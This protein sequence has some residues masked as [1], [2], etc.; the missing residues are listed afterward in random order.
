MT[1]D[2]DRKPAHIAHG[3]V[4]GVKHIV[5]CWLCGG[6][7]G[8]ECLECMAASHRD[9]RA[10]YC[11]RCSEAAFFLRFYRLSQKVRNDE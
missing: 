2:K 11:K 9:G 4:T 10:V 3:E 8:P 1:K 6:Y 5:P 7:H